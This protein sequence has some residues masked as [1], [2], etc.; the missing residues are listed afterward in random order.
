MFLQSISESSIVNGVRC[1]RSLSSTVT[2]YVTRW[3]MRCFELRITTPGA[4][5][6]M[7]PIV[8]PSI[9]VFGVEIVEGPVYA[10][11]IVPDC[12][13]VLPSPGN[14]AVEPEP[15]GDGGDGGEGADG[16][17]AGLDGG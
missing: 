6:S 2:T 1:Q 9:T 8:F 13:P 11:N 12:T 7:H 17:E 4:V 5:T 10:V 14:P 3:H 15:G 16:G